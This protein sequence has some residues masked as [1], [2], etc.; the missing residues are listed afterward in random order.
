VEDQIKK[1]KIVV[2]EIEVYGALQVK[3]KFPSAVLIFLMPPTLTELSCRLRKRGTEDDVTIEA[4]LKKALEEVPLIDRYNY[5]VINDVVPDAVEKINAIVSAE[6]MRPS[7]SAE[8]LK[9]F[10]GEHEEE[11]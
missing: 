7:R 2:L 4:R 6:R 3:E 8:E 5:L 11:I 9:K 1:G 10:I